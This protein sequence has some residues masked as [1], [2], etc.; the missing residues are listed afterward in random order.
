MQSVPGEEGAAQKVDSG[1]LRLQAGGYRRQR[2]HLE[3]ICGQGRI[4][5]TLESQ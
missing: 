5:P 2:V 4:S 1:A 3:K